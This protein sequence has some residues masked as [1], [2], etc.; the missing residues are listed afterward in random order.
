MFISS[1]TCRPAASGG[2]SGSEPV[3]SGSRFRSYG[4]S[5]SVREVA[6]PLVHMECDDQ[7]RGVRPA[8][9]ATQEV[10]R[11]KIAIISPANL[12]RP[13]PVAV[14]ENR[15][16]V[17]MESCVAMETEEISPG[18][19]AHSVNSDEL[20][21]ARCRGV[22]PGHID[23]CWNDPRWREKNQAM[24]E[25]MEQKIQSGFY[26]DTPCAQFTLRSPDQRYKFELAVYA[27]R[28]PG[29]SGYSNIR[30]ISNQGARVLANINRNLEDLLFHSFRWK[31]DRCIL[32]GH[33][34]MAPL[35]V[36]LNTGKIYEQRGDQYDDWELMWQF[37]EASP[38][39]KTF[40]VEGLLWGGF[41]AEYRFYDASKPDRGFRYL[42]PGLIMSIPDDKD[43]TDPEWGIDEDGRTTVSLTVR[44]GYCE[45][46]CV[47][48]NGDPVI[49]KKTFRREEGRMV[50]VASETIRIDNNSS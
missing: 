28:K 48:E 7:K 39:G 44:D 13:Y 29:L 14:E 23:A 16:A 30:I 22:S 47:D 10:A 35:V 4:V 42:P 17:S 50:E 18:T 41:P 9:P 21:H 2:N 11:K 15:R 38:D 26:C 20:G 27:S 24:R 37:V 34:Y 32:S 40:L 43:A 36:N 25:K 12:N 49:F 3:S 6:A 33:S 5:H 8:E 19:S 31:G 45:D 1:P 46:D